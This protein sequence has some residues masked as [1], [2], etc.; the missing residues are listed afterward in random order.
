MKAKAV[1]CR[2]FLSDIEVG[3]VVKNKSCTFRVV[4]IQWKND[5]VQ[6]FATTIG[7]TKPFPSLEGNP[8]DIITVYQRQEKK[9]PA[10]KAPTKTGKTTGPAKP[11]LGW[12]SNE[13][14]G[15]V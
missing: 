9:E 3:D 7:L 13:T 6:L 8:F 10:C 11:R 4:R 15:S 14:K 1:S 2:A 5:R 12:S